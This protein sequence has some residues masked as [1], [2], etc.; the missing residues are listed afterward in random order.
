MRTGLSFT[1]ATNRLDIDVASVALGGALTVNG[2]L[3]MGKGDDVALRLRGVTGDRVTLGHT[4]LGAYQV[5]VI[6]G[7]Y[8][9]FVDYG[10]SL[11]TAPTNDNTL[12]R[13]D[14]AVSRDTVLDL[15]VPSVQ[16]T[17]K[18]LIDGLPAPPATIGGDF[19]GVSLRTDGGATAFIGVTNIAMYKIYALAGTYDVYYQTQS[20]ANGAVPRNQNVKI[21]GGV[22]VAAPGPLTFDVNIPTRVMRGG[23]TVNG[24]PLADAA[25]AGR[26]ELWS[27]SGDKALLGGTEAG[28]YDAR[29]VPGTYDVVYIG[30]APGAM[31]PVNQATRLGCLIVE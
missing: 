10:A 17:G 20:F 24:T 26:L 1:A 13:A 23:I 16:V 19:G 29:L 5:H 30:S 21:G 12:L 15:D 22:V 14:V 7:T 28:A 6:P 3:D 18:F 4:N 11:I 2:A 25:D 27:A 8:Q 9:V 31:A